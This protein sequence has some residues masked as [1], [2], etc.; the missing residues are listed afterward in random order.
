MGIQLVWDNEPPTILRCTFESNWSWDD[1]YVVADQVKAITD[2]ADHVVA[3]II[4]LSA[5]ITIPGGTFFSPTSL[6]NAR[7]LLT[8]GE[9]GTGPIAVVGAGRTLQLVY[10]TFKGLDPR[11]A[12]ANVTF[13]DNLQAARAHLARIHTPHNGAKPSS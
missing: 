3:A 8:L 12:T 7:K 1:L 13:V 11:A 6:T 10:E 9:G 2:K 5:G 4:D